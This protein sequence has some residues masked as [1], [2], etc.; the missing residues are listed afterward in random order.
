MT[1]PRQLRWMIIAAM[2]FW[3]APISPDAAE[4][5]SPRPTGQ[6]HKNSVPA[7]DPRRSGFEDMSR[8]TQTLQRDDGQNP[9][10]L[11]VRDGERQWRQ[12]PGPGQ[13]SC[14]DC[15]GDAEQSMRGVAAA[16]PAWDRLLG[17]PVNLAHRIN[18]CRRNHQL[19]EPLDAGSDDLLG[20]EA[21]IALQSRG[22]SIEPVID[23]RLLHARQNGQRL[24]AMKI[25]QL[26]MSCAQ[27]HDEHPGQRL[28]GSTIPQGHPTAYPI[29]RLQWQS[30]G[31]LT[32]RL[33]ACLT[34]VR[35]RQFP[36]FGDEMVAL[37]LFLRHRAAGMPFEGPGVRP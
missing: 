7:G 6:D 10:M 28:G 11:W 27:C 14:A 26:A 20:L 9:A 12:A 8:A 3:L 18:L 13:R 32:R 30:A 37:E 33:Q 35:A 22:L 17:R 29:Y 19:L 4:P 21:F 23:E 5:A 25:G 36:P 31:S 16:Y 2:L 34:G 24:F 15:H 1:R